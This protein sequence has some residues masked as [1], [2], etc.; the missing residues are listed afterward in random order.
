MSA[1]ITVPLLGTGASPCMAAVRVKRYFDEVKVL[2]ARK[3]TV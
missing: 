2:F 1:D 3:Y